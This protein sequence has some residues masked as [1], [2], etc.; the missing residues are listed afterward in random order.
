LINYLEEKHLPYQMKSENTI[1]N[2]E[3]PQLINDNDEII[4]K[5]VIKIIDS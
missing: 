3:L 5:N 4:L 2:I 1:F